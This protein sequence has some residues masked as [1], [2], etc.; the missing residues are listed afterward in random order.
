MDLREATRSLCTPGANSVPLGRRPEP[1]DRL[2]RARQQEPLKVLTRTA[3]NLG[4]G[5][6]VYL[7]TGTAAKVCG[8]LVGGLGAG[9][10]V[11][12]LAGLALCLPTLLLAGR[13]SDKV[14]TTAMVGGLLA[15]LAGGILGGGLVGW[16][17][18]GGGQGWGTLALGLSSLLMARKG[19]GL[20]RLEEEHKA[21]LEAWEKRRAAIQSGEVPPPLE[22]LQPPSAIEELGNMILVGG[23][24][25]PNKRRP[26]AEE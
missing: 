5:A 8:A 16:H 25:L 15:G 12:G 18:A 20:Q 6:G 11:G 26:V 9:A 7:M 1:S 4:L 17:V 22:P 19:N 3:A 24:R 23:I 2:L 21:E 10:M 13:V 14:L